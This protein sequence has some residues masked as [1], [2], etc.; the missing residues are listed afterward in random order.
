MIPATVFFFL[1]THSGKLVSSQKTLALD[2]LNLRLVAVNAP[3]L[4]KD[5]TSCGFKLL[6]LIPSLEL[7]NL[8][9]YGETPW[10]L[11]KTPHPVAL[12]FYF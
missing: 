10:C 12:N 3:A 5:A 6:F 9:I 4:A 11:L 7:K 1:V 8:R 2:F